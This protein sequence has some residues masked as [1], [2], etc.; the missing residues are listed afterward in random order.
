MRNKTLILV[1]IGEA[2]LCA[3]AALILNYDNAG[4]LTVMQFPFAQIGMLLRG[5]SL[6]GGLGN[7]AAFIVY[8]AICTVP[9]VFVA[10]HMRKKTFKAEDGLL[11]VMSGFGFYMMYMMINPALL[12]QTPVFFKQDFGKAILGGALYAILIGYLVLKI[13]RRA[14]HSKTD[15]LL[16]ILRLL[17]AITAIVIV[18]GISYMG[19]GDVK[20]KLAA[21]QSGN[22]DPSV[23]LSFT[24]FFVVVSYILTQMPAA[25]QIVIFLLAMQLCDDLRVDK[26]GEGAINAAK[27]LAVFCKIAVVVTMLSCIVINLA[28]IVFAG[29]LVSVDYNTILPLD[30]ILVALTALLLTRFFI[31]SSELS[32]DNKMFI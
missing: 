6:S 24:N 9:I 20:M 17:I 11:V 5:L 27:K 21:I 29:S 18:F 31:A 32:Q 4:Y 10:V 25:T 22:T 16:K 30:S 8:V 2:I 13:L 15:S 7:V 26:F 28:Q 14:E 1:L 3:I 12:G 19:I 23:S